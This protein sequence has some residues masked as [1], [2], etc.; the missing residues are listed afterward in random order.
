VRSTKPSLTN[1]SLRMEKSHGNKG[2]GFPGRSCSTCI[3][4]LSSHPRQ[5]RR[6]SPRANPQRHTRR[7]CAFSG[8][9]GMRRICHLF[10]ISARGKRQ[11]K[12]AFLRRTTYRL[13]RVRMSLAYMSGRSTSRQLDTWVILQEIG[14]LKAS[15]EPSGPSKPKGHTAD[16]GLASMA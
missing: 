14:G 2:R 4:Y 5:A 3:R 13:N 16:D 1:H 15:L 10:A 11:R 7:G 8:L 6:R 9:Q 12:R